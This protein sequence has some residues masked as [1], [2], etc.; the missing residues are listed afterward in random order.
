[1]ALL[2]KLGFEETGR[3]ERT[4]DAFTLVTDEDIPIVNDIERALGSYIEQRWVEGFDYNSARPA[5]ADEFKRGP[6]PGGRG[7]RSSFGGGGSRGGSSRGGSHGGPG[8]G[9]R[10]GSSSRGGGSSS[11]G[12]E[13]RSNDQAPGERLSGGGGTGSSPRPAGAPPRHRRR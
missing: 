1:L 5:G 4:G 3:A 8:G 10:S 13:V 2:G 6:H 9:T 12:R 7:G 11:G